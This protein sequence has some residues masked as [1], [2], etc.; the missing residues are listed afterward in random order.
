MRYPIGSTLFSTWSAED[1]EALLDQGAA[2]HIDADSLAALPREPGVYTFWGEGR[3]PL[4]IGKSVNIRQRVLSHLRNAAEARLVAQTRRIDFVRMAGDI[5]AQLLEARLIKEQQ[6]LFNVRLR[7]SRKLYAIRLGPSPAGLTPQVV[8]GDQVPLGREPHLYGLHASRHAALDFL[9]T[10]ARGHQLCLGLLGL[11]KIGQRGCF[12]PQIKT[13]RGAC[14]GREDRAAHDARLL[15]A[16]R[17][18]QVHV[19]PFAGPV[20]VVEHGP[21]GVQ[22]HRVDNWR[23][24]GSWVRSTRELADPS[25]P[26]IKGRRPRP[27][28][29][30][31]GAACQLDLDTYKILI[32]PILLGEVSVHVPG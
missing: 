11:E 9:R 8:D 12:G 3:L 16:L 22:K 13:C 29:G 1:N 31:S 23:Y 5:G 26:S 20:D 19:W 18:A 10:L 24:L 30:A 4:Y 6:P 21:M 14:V 25:S 2:R 17:E 7:R 15:E 28:P 27:V 32:R